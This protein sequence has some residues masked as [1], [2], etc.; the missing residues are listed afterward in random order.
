[1]VRAAPD[2]KYAGEQNPGDRTLYD[3]A[4][5]QSEAERL[6]LQAEVY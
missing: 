5:K 1:M 4:E 2:G 6:G 3:A